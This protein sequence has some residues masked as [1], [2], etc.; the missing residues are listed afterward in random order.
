MK[1]NSFLMLL[2]MGVLAL[3]PASAGAVL[4]NFDNFAPG[5]NINGLHIGDTA[6]NGCVITSFSGQTVVVNDFGVGFRSAPNALTNFDPA[7]I[8]PGNPMTITFD[9]PR[10]LVAFTG[11]DRGGDT[12][13]F[14]VD[15]FDNNGNL[16]TSLTTPVFGGNAPDPMIMVDF[17]RV[18]FVDIGYIKKIVIR[19]AINAGIGIDDLEFCH[20]APIPGSLLLLGSG[21]LGLVGLRKK[22]SL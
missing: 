18:Q 13:Q 2:L 6:P 22:I 11:G 10:G 21:I 15:A 7:F 14:T 17:Y 20:P 9:I 3:V 1:K 16:I 5:Q 8:T 12:D 4:V 19:D